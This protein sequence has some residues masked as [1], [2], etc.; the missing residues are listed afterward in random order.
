MTDSPA[1]DLDT[2]D[3]AGAPAVITGGL[4]PDIA[5][6]VPDEPAGEPVP[7]R[8]ATGLAG[9]SPSRCGCSAS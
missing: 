7:E 5:T 2:D 6:P 4:T 3:E 9:S 8:R 1:L